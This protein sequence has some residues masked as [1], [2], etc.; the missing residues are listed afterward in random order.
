MAIVAMGL[1][2]M[3]DIG[4]A[5]ISLGI[6]SLLSHDLG[7]E[8]LRLSARVAV[9]TTAFLEEA[10]YFVII[11]MERPTQKLKSVIAVTLITPAIIVASIPHGNNAN[12][13]TPPA[14]ASTYEIAMF[15]Y[16]TSRAWGLS[17]PGFGTK[18]SSTILCSTR[19]LQEPDH[20]VALDSPLELE[21]LAL[22]SFTTAAGFSMSLQLA[23][24]EC[25]GSKAGRRQDPY[26]F[27]GRSD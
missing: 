14:I 5:A 8:C 21:A 10:S 9:C 3:G 24:S 27:N 25:A 2:G 16:T 22:H 4:L 15:I 7:A 26:S 23:T 6:I 13:Y 19:L 11:P 12:L 1:C 18:I 20:Y 17:N